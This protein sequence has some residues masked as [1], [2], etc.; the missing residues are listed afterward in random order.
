MQKLKNYCKLY[1]LGLFYDKL[2]LKSKV[3]LSITFLLLLVHFCLSFGAHYNFLSHFWD[4]G[5]HTQPLW[6]Y[7]HG[8][9]AHFAGDPK[10][11]MLSDHFSLSL[12]LY[13]PLV[14]IFK[15]YTLLVI[16]YIF[17][18]IGVLGIWQ[19]LKHQ[20]P[21]VLKY[22]P[23][24]YMFFLTHWG[25]IAAMNYDFH[26]NVPA[27]MLIPWLILFYRQQKKIQFFV[28]LT[29]MLI[30]QENVSFYCAM[31]LIALTLD[32]LWSL[33]KDSPQRDKINLN[34]Y[35]WR[36]I[37]TKVPRWHYLSI[38]ICFSY[39]FL[40][41]SFVLPA[42]G[43]PA[44]NTYKHLGAGVWE[45]AW[46]IISEPSRILIPYKLTPDHMLAIVYTG[47][48]IMFFG[49]IYLPIFR[50]WMLIALL[51]YTAQRFLSS[52]HSYWVQHFQYSVELTPFLSIILIDTLVHWHR[53]KIKF[54]PLLKSLL[55]ILVITS[56]MASAYN[57]GL[58]YKFLTIYRMV[59]DNTIWGNL[60]RDEIKQVLALVPDSSSIVT[61]DLF[62]PRLY[63]R[64]PGDILLIEDFYNLDEQELKPFKYLLFSSLASYYNTS[65]IDSMRKMRAKRLYVRIQEILQ[66]PRFIPIYNSKHLHL[67]LVPYYQDKSSKVRK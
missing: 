3:S 14:Y 19:Y 30:C 40:I 53:K 10:R 55:T 25:I 52:T 17:L 22:S 4:L 63:R 34:I 31:L 47:L 24:I 26:N 29:F 45:I 28:V 43:Y 59:R 12:I 38:L 8:K 2:S 62:S 49:G 58:R 57:A 35:I 41:L 64:D 21:K 18:I 56:A 48:V 27:A 46:N 51:G 67:L 50:P 39:F 16:Q 36:N 37:I 65:S 23:W 60:H 7:A 6:Q 1:H 20:A 54:L 11:Y 13:S 66:D 5:V 32:K 15:S 33:W 44:I 9:L 61:H 42:M